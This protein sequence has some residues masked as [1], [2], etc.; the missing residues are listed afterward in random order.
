LNRDKLPVD[1]LD[2]LAKLEERNTVLIGGRMAYE[3]RKQVLF[4]Y[5]ADLR[6]ARTLKLVESQPA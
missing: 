2:D 6:K 1:D 4:A 5:A 3:D